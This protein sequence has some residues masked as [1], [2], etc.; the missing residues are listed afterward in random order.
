MEDALDYCIGALAADPDQDLV[1]ELLE[2][3]RLTNSRFRIG[4]PRSLELLLGL[5]GDDAIEAGAG[6]IEEDEDA[7][8]GSGAMED[9]DKED[10]EPSETV[11]RAD[12]GSSG[13]DA[14][15]SF[16]AA[17]NNADG[18]ASLL[19][20]VSVTESPPQPGRRKEADQFAA[21]SGTE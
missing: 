14:D 17:A 6:P 16:A 3:G 20:T 13:E 9:G 7:T 21:A 2:L 18:T 1:R 5:G 8:V 19:P 10:A 12:T 11:G 15:A 4:V